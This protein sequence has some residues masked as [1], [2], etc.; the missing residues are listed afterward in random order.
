MNLSNFI[1]DIE[2][3]DP[4]VYDRLDSRRAVFK[5]MAG[6]GKK[7]AMAAVPFA[8]GSVLNKAYGQTNNAQ[9]VID[10]L[11]FALTLEFIEDEFYKAG[12]AAMGGNLIPAADK[13]IFNQIGKHE[14]A[15]VNFL[16]VVIRDVLKGTPAAKPRTDFTGSKNGTRPA[17]FP[18]VFTNYGTFKAV[19]QA[20]EDTGVRAYKGQAGNL[21]SNNVVLDAALQIHSVEARHA[22]EVRRLNGKKGW[23]EGNDGNGPA[24]GKTDAIYKGEEITTQAGVN[25]ATISSSG[26][27]MNAN[28][29]S[30]AFDEPL[31]KDET[32]AIAANFIF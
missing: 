7:L 28:S 16:T 13:V 5:G 29:A 3:F 15:H 2:K 9:L 14:T 22:A 6:F 23:I 21:V 19:A 31:T 12:L 20:F 24:P 25:I 10:T 8:F 1:H 32:L 26:V 30:A 4:E 11:N 18:D 27:T 17:L